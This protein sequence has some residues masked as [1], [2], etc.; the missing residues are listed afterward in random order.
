MKRPLCSAVVAIWILLAAV[1]AALGQPQPV[2]SRLSL[3]EAV[4]LAAERNPQAAAARA[5]VDIAEANRVDAR[6]RP[7]PAVSVESESYPLFESPRPRFFDGQELTIRF[8]QEIETAGRR[9]L[10]TDVAD[11]GVAVANLTARDRLRQLELAV[12]RAYLQLALA[13]ADAEVAR[14]SLQEIDRVLTVGRE[15]VRVGEAARS[16]V[17]RLEVERLRFAEDAFA[18]DL[19]LRNARAALLT[20]LGASDLTQP[21]E[22]A[23]SLEGTSTVAAV[24]VS[25]APAAP[26]Q[27]AAV[28]GRPDLLAAREE[29]RRAETETRLQRALRAPNVT[30]GGGYRRDFGTNVVV[31]GVTIPVPL[32]N[33]NQGGLARAT[34]EREL[35]AS[36]LSAVE[37][38]VRLDIQQAINA[39]ETNRA[40]AEYIEREILSSA[41]QSRDV[42]SES[43]RLGAADLIDFLDAQRAFRDTLRTYNRALFD[44]RV[45]VFELNAAR[46]LTSIQQ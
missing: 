38:D 30:I 28:D 25:T 21:L 9:R 4:R 3:E 13:Q 34:A 27:P 15:R 6:L 41:R 40:R 14:T 42:V 1:A 36:S 39:V 7:N 12:R 43:Y 29:L 22:A 44:Y 45:S 32:W 46:G 20:L 10:R 26:A 16:E 31:F 8:D 2:P 37:L 33:R 17:S 11:A 24:A 23:D 5:L 18:A 19:S 35:A